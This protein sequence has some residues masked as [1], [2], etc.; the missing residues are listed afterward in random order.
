MVLVR[1]TGRVAG[2]PSSEGAIATAAAPASR[3][4]REQPLGRLGLA[5]GTLHRAVCV[6]DPADLLER[7]PAVPTP[8]FVERHAVIHDA[9]DRGEVTGPLPLLRKLL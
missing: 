8:V 1:P 4:G 3:E 6:R 7:P 2:L 9:G 5:M